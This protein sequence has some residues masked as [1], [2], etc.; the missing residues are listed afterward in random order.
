MVQLCT[1]GFRRP[2]R[3]PLGNDQRGQTMMD[4]HGIQQRL[5]EFVGQETEYWDFWGAI[6]V[7]RNGKILW[8]TS[9]GYSCAE[10]GVKNT[11][12][13]R[14]TVASVTKQFTAFAVMLLADR[15]LLCLEALN[16]WCCLRF[17][18]V[19]LICITPVFASVRT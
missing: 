16:D 7:I 3:N 15:G 1:G 5:A 19:F 12:A 8:E 17:C 4:E 9:R 10:F 18:F 2:L 11:M 14:F 6:R 13:T